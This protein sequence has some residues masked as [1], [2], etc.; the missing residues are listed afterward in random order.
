MDQSSTNPP[1]VKNV[2]TSTRDPRS[3]VRSDATRLEDGQTNEAG[4]EN[5]D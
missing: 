3:S 2:L 4:D 5:R 1:N